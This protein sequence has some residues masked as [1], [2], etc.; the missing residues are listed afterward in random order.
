MSQNEAKLMLSGSLLVVLV[1]AVGINASLF[2]SNNHSRQGSG[3]SAPGERSIASINPIFRISWEKKAFEVL[4]H[5]QERDLA[6]VGKLPSPMDHFRFGTL[7]GLYNIRK[8]DGKI[9]EVQ[10]FEQDGNEAKRLVERKT[11]LDQ[12]I[13]FFS[14][15][16]QSVKKIH[17][18]NNQQRLVE[19][20]Q[21]LDS[22]GETLG[23]IQ[24]LLDQDQKLLSMTV[25]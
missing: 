7:E 16:A 10:F 14:D 20:Y 19:K 8:V 21:M 15:Q 23:T 13:A 9:S 24:V 11:Y 22:K 2:T 1:L 4:E 25:Q 12:H 6:N 3:A 18:Q 5:T 17:E